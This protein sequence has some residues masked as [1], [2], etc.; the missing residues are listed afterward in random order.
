VTSL[1]IFVLSHDD[2]LLAA[3][4]AR[5]ELR[6]VDLRDLGLAGELATNSLAEC[7]FFLSERA[8]DVTTEYVGVLSARHDEKY[9]P[10]GVLTLE[11][12][13]QGAIT[14][15]LRPRRVFAP[16]ITGPGGQWVEGSDLVHPGL[17]ALVR[18]AAEQIPGADVSRRTM[19][20]SSF[21][22]HRDVY[23]EFIAE[24]RRL[25]ET[26]HAR[27]GLDFPHVYRCSRCGTVFEGGH[28][29]Y[30]RDRHGAYFYER[31]TA[32][33]F[34]RPQ[35]EVVGLRG[36]SFMSRPRFAREVWRSA[37]SQVARYRRDRLR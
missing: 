35:F 21:I 29:R 13:A 18:E 32:L 22:A 1:S 12:L 31:V 16:L 37:R 36:G 6:R 25:F 2:A 3:V 20:A 27:Y 34:A 24:F 5:S 14:P 19:L 33:Y 30:Q 9:A 4:P 23:L 28:G 26:F 15:Y 11:Q 7:R 17:T 8:L 10:S